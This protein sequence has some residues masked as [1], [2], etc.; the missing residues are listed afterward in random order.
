MHPTRAADLGEVEGR[1]DAAVLR[2]EVDYD[3]SKL[4]LDKGF[5]DHLASLMASHRSAGKLE[6]T[7]AIKRETE[8]FSSAG[9]LSGSDLV[10]QPADLLAAQQ[11][12]L[13]ALA[14]HDAILNKK[15][16]K[17]YEV[18]ISALGSL[19][20]KL[21][22][23]GK[24]DEAEQVASKLDLA[25]DAHRALVELAEAARR[26]PVPDG[27]SEW[28]GH[29]YLVV[30]QSRV[31]FSDARAACEKLGGH[32]VF[33]GSEDERKF[34]HKLKGRKTSWIGASDQ[35]EEGTYT[36]LDGSEIA[37]ELRNVISQTN[38]RV[39]DCVLLTVDGVLV[40][41]PKSGHHKSGIEKWVNRYVIEWDY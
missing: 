26:L 32:L 4:R 6:S 30:V 23:A 12:Y 9:E 8:R 17:A 20:V 24:I 37:K 33:L 34:V 15:K 10:E 25:T 13:E 14:T 36:W 41:R 38:T 11:R 22:M 18:Y 31:S 7:L 39:Y 29:H 27:A 3:E 1:F 16:S 28:Q 2:A 35:D 21:T 5:T 40:S 19:K